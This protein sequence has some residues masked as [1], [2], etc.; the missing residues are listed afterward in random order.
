MTDILMIKPVVLPS[1]IVFID[2]DNLQHA[3]AK[4]SEHVS[5]QYYVSFSQKICT[6]KALLHSLIN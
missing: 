2:H 6:F 1:H 3:D 5:Q 4:V